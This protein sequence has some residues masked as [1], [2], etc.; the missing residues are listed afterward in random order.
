MNL[1]NLDFLIYT[2]SNTDPKYQSNFFNN[3]FN[4]L[5][6]NQEL[7]QQIIEGFSEYEIRKTWATDL[8]E[9]QSIRDQYLL[10]D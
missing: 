7:Q 2:Y 1:L 3:Y 4:K 9:F 5:A 10:Y 8:L 6:G